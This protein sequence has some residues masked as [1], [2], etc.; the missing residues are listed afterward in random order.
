MHVVIGCEP[1]RHRA[2]RSPST[3]QKT[4][5]PDVRVRPPSPGRTSWSAW[6]E[7][8]RS[9][10]RR[11]SR[12]AGIRLLAGPAA[13]R[14]GRRRPRRCPPPW[15]LASECSPP[16]IPK[17]RPQR[18][19]LDRRRGLSSSE[20]AQRRSANHSQVLRLLAKRNGTSAVI[21]LGSICRLH[22]LLVELARGNRQGTLRFRRRAAP[23]QRRA[24]D[25]GQP[26]TATTSPSS[27]S[28]TCADSTS[29]PRSRAAES[30]SPSRHRGRR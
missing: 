28:T 27:C 19:P 1:T 8:S 20:P 22:A 18:R 16:V 7:P 24:P 17:Q 23:G 30:A 4:S 21:G 2:P 12:P 10:P 13:R 14:A 6:A 26:G 3:R 11:S 9:E 25:P 5:S 29:R 15:P